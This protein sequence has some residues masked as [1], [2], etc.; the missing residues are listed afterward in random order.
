MNPQQRHRPPA[1]P[2]I[3]LAAA[4]GITTAQAQ[5]AIPSASR[6]TAVDTSKPGFKFR[7]FANKANT[8]NNNTR[9]E[10]ALAGRLLAGD[11]TP[12]PNL[13]NP[14]SQG[15]ALDVSADPNPANAPISF[16]IDTVI[17]LNKSGGGGAGNFKPDLGMPGVPATDGSSDGL[18]AEIITYLDLPAGVI[19]M[20][21]NSDDGFRTSAGVLND[22]LRRVT[23]GEYEGGR[24]AGDTIFTFTVPEA[25]IYPFRTSY[26][27]GGG[28]ANIEW[29]TVAQ[30]GTKIL[31]NDVDNG[32]IKAYRAVVPSPLDPY[33]SSV[34]P[35]PGN[36]QQNAVYPKVEV[37][38][39]DG[40]AVPIDDGTTSLTVDGRLAAKKRSGN[41]L[42]L[43]YDPPGIQFPFDTHQATLVI[44]GKAAAFTRTD[45]W[46]FRN[47]KK[48]ILPSPLIL[49]NFDSYQEGTQPTDWVPTNF[50]VDCTPGEDITNQKSDTYKNWVVISTDTIPLIDDDGI[51]NVNPTETLNGVPITIDVL[52][53]GNVLYAESDSRCNGSRSA[54]ISN[55]DGA[56]GQTQFIVT[57]PYNL[58]A[59][60]APVLSFNSAYEQNQ[61]SYGGVEYSVDGG[62]TWMPVVYF[63]DVPDI[64]VRPDGTTD[65]VT[66]LTQPQGDTSLW[67]VDGVVKGIAYG[68]AA[69]AP[70]VDGIGDYIVPRIN[71]NNTEGKRIEIFRLPAAAGKADVRLRFS[72][73][74]SD[75]WYWFVD[76][77][78]FY[79]IPVASQYVVIPPASRVT[80]DTSKP[81]FKF[82][83]FANKANTDNNNTRTEDALAGRLLAGDGTPL[84]NLAN[85]QAQGAALDVA[86][87]PDPLNAP[88]NFEIDSVINLNKGA[89]GGAGN[90]KPDLGMPG[91]PATDGSSDGLAAEI[92]TYIELPAGLVTMGVNSDDGFRTSAGALND[93]LQRVTVGE[94]EG[95]RGAGDT[96]FTFQVI[97]PGIYPFRTS[98]EQGGGDANIEWF[99]VAADG[100][101]ILVND[102]ENG[103]VKA[104]RAT[105]AAPAAPYVKSVIP[106]PGDR[107]LNAVYPKVEVVLVDGDTAIIDDAATT[108]LVDGKAAAK[109]RTGHTLTLTYDPKGIQFPFD[110]HKAE[111]SIKA[112]GGY[113]RKEQWVFRNLKK[114]VLPT[115]LILENFDSYDEGTQPTDWVPTNFTID[116][117]PGEDIHNQKSDTYKNWVVISTDTIPFIDDDGITEVN[118]TETLNGIPVT[119]DM[120]RSGNVLYAESDSRCNGS[121]SGVIANNDGLYGQTQFI[122]TKPYNL[123]KV[124]DPVLSFSSA[125]EQNQDS[126]GGVEYSVDGGASWMPVVYFLDVPDISVR[127]DGT[128]DGV[129]TLNQLQGDTS[130]WTV[131][132]FVKGLSYG[133]AAAA[134][135][136]EGIGNYIVPRINDNHTEGKRIEIFRLPAA[137]G[138][139]D[140]RLRFSAT[141]SDSWYWFVDNVAL[142]DIPSPDSAN[143]PQVSIARNGA[144]VVITFTG[145]LEFASAMSASPNWQP[146]VGAVSPLTIKAAQLTGQVFYRAVR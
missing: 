107:Q 129:T 29:F 87:D 73:T 35:A 8:D 46:T 134:P 57:K 27:Q 113:V 78:A 123:S 43:T 64:V 33:V 104:Y 98:Y 67:T 12:L 39:V 26:E 22:A 130:L 124:T 132:G 138:K 133:D 119:I 10:D 91:V 9:T 116:C 2:Y 108:L 48:V 13:A 47:L 61:D 6:V 144:D 102:T 62:T 135:I 90:F 45:T 55:N 40:D 37:V 51:T 36:R 63:L 53:S 68:D 1:W 88:I 59:V 94:Y 142:Y 103:G 131:D 106:Q 92:I 74:G 4:L 60:G 41:T 84:P 81:G 120:L 143:S 105:A 127:P 114:V 31:L 34:I 111:L 72:A 16:E 7:I 23:L 109:S 52:R 70:I 65:G 96:I 139:S 15:A 93:A 76:N 100:T 17:N 32:G 80:P 83:I 97:E 110:S 82:S 86:T 49:E 77:V 75:S 11:G 25:G 66:T 71:D 95:G 19:T 79:D 44:N 85:P 5:I 146:V 21:V 89:G 24:G 140:V 28:D 112:A 50:T 99:T 115:P 56:Y 58:S 54:V 14:Q 3:C 18:A 137:A 126:Y 20:G 145:T 42:T 30:D 69:A 125:Y 136:V 121:R 38:L 141:G 101:K 117:T 118:P 128:T 122:V